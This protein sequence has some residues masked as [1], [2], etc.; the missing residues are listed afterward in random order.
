MEDSNELVF[1][2][3]YAISELLKSAGNTM[4]GVSN[5]DEV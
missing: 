3:N 4:D 1:N 5:N 2:S